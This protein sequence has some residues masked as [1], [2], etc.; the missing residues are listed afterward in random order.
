MQKLHGYDMRTRETSALLKIMEI[1]C[2]PSDQYS[3]GECLDM[4]IDVLDQIGMPIKEE[5]SKMNA[6]YSVRD[7]SS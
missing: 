3:D 4:I 7:I 6:R 5:I 1:V 2:L